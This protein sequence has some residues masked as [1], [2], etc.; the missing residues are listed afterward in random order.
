MYAFQLQLFYSQIHDL[1]LS[2]L[3]DFIEF[4][5]AFISF[6]SA[7]N[8][9]FYILLL[10]QSLNFCLLL[11]GIKLR[12]I[13]LESYLKIHFLVPFL[14]L[15]SNDFF[16]SHHHIHVIIRSFCFFFRLNFLHAFQW[17]SLL[18]QFISI[19][20]IYARHIYCIEMLTINCTHAFPFNLSS[21]LSIVYVRS[22]LIL[23][24]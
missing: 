7:I 14:S 16:F 24:D 21:H 2:L 22:F 6:F 15:S 4:P 13:K 20:Y 5:F 1:R 18:S 10:N 17:T 12:G 9:L 11:S 19:I 3:P 23:N 8:F